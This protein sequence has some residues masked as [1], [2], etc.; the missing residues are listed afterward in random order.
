MNNDIL[1][2][3]LIAW[4]DSD[5][6]DS[7][8][9]K[10]S[11]VEKRMKYQLVY[12]VDEFKKIK[13]FNISQPSL[14]YKKYK[15]K[16]YINGEHIELDQNGYTVNEYKPGE[17][18]VYIDGFNKHKKIN[19]RTFLGCT[20]LIS[21]EI[22]NSVTY[23]GYNAFMN[24]TGL[25]KIKIPDSVTE[26]SR[27]TFKNCIGLTSVTIP[28]S[29]TK[30]GEYAFSGCSGLSKIEI[31]DSVTS[32]GENAFA[33]CGGLTSITIPN[34]VTKI[35]KEV[36]SGC[37]SLTSITIPN[38]V[39]SIGN[40]A[41]SWCSSLTSMTIPNSVT[42]ISDLAFWESPNIK[43]IYVESIDKFN[44]IKFLG[45]RD[46]SKLFKNIELIE[47]KQGLNEALLQW[48]DSDIEDSG[49][50]LSKNDIKYSISVPT[51]DQI[52]KKL[53][54]M[55]TKL[56]KGNNSRWDYYVAPRSFNQI[57]EIFKAFN[58]N[59]K[60]YWENCN[61]KPEGAL[62]YGI[63]GIIK[64]ANPC[65]SLISPIS[66]SSSIDY[67]IN[68]EKTFVEVPC[69]FCRLRSDE[70]WNIYYGITKN[71]EWYHAGWSS[72]ENNFYSD[73]NGSQVWA[74]RENSSL[75][76]FAIYIQGILKI[77]ADPSLVNKKL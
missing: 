69:L 18:C 51:I 63:D 45:R 35:G 38:S 25:T 1:N 73:I 76:T 27:W 49:G 41:F 8:L 46:K 29:V 5:I 67:T 54:T 23:I 14:I 77:Y 61:G 59:I 50:I 56:P 52:I 70:T 33:G 12:K 26:I 11:D 66:V 6:E 7:G 37:S 24:C 16:I 28:N 60:I 71:G 65:S 39:T 55:L 75:R 34:S 43:T 22:P 48:N 21:I 74:M 17:Y 62:I 40:Y 68:G 31:P 4:G 3:I 53:K 36:F 42:E 19:G 72:M 30:I 13:I 2:K 15:D 9:I 58:P 47:L 20:D 32:I 10:A 64:I 44:K 57:C